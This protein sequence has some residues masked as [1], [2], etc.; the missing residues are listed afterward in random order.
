M[1]E[2]IVSEK[3]ENKTSETTVGSQRPV[4]RRAHKTSRSKVIV[5]DFDLYKIPLNIDIDFVIKEIILPRVPDGYA[6]Q[7]NEILQKRPNRANPDF[8]PKKAGETDANHC[9]SL[10]DYLVEADSPRRLFPVSNRAINVEIIER[11]PREG[12]YLLSR[13]LN[14]LN[15]LQAEELPQFLRPVECASEHAIESISAGV[16]SEG[17]ETGGVVDEATAAGLKEDVTWNQQKRSGDAL[18]PVVTVEEAT[19]KCDDSKSDSSSDNE[20]TEGR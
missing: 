6:F 8:D 18:L 7:P 20:L 15:E 17:S 5:L 13:L 12:E 1:D 9:E 3:I 16:E 11:S 2:T 14:E 19:E 4:T 10:T